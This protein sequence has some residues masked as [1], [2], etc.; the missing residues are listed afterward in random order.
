MALLPWFDFPGVELI[1]FSIGAVPLS[2]IIGVNVRRHYGLNILAIHRNGRFL[3]SPA[4]DLLF[5]AEDTLLVMGEKNDIER[6]EA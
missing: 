4:P 1:T 3:V 5:E 6:L 2:S